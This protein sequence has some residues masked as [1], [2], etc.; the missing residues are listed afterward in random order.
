M[1]SIILSTL[2]VAFVSGISFGIFVERGLWES[3]L[4]RASRRIEAHRS[5]AER[6][7]GFRVIDGGRPLPVTTS[8]RTIRSVADNHDEWRRAA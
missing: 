5:A 2:I 6:R 7:R 4:K 8:R 1:W 3:A